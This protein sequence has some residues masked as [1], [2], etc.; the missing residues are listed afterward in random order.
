M[1]NQTFHIKTK[2]LNHSNCQLSFG[3]Y[4][5]GSTALLIRSSQGEPLIKVTSYLPEVILE[6][7]QIIVKDYSENEGILQCLIELEIIE[8][9]EDLDPITSGFAILNV[10][11]LLINPADYQPNW[12]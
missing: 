8:E 11:K 2:Y 7:D 4:Q 3:K 12:S 5:D 1:S 9:L 10:C 6:E